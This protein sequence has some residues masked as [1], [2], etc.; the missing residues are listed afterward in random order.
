M[1]VLSAVVKIP[2]LTVLDPRENL[3]LGRAIALECIGDD[4]AWNILTPFEELTEELLRRVRVPS[5]L[6]QDIEH[7]SVLIHCTP[8]VVALFVDRDEHLIQ[9][10]CITRTGTA[11]TQSIRIGLAELPAPFADGF[12]RDDDAPGTQELFDVTVAQREAKI[13]LDSVA[14]DLTRKPMMFV[15]IGCGWVIRFVPYP[16]TAA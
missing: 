6:H 7:I 4:H 11:P 2:M 1:G 12:V 16:D 3:P 13:Q 14:D 15:W 8:Q 9:M 10:P 5:P